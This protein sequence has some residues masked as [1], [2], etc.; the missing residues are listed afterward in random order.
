MWQALQAA[1]GYRRL[2]GGW[3]RR[4]GGLD[5][6]AGSGQGKGLCWGETCVCLCLKFVCTSRSV[7]LLT[8]WKTHAY[9][10]GQ[11]GFLNLEHNK[12][13]EVSN[14]V[15]TNNWWRFYSLIRQ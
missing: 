12:R 10:T 11:Y 13:E 3:R 7:G 14:F 2:E 9:V 6:P 4:R 15:L 1:A 8:G 5:L